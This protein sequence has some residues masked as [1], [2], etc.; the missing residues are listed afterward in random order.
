MKLADARA[1]VLAKAQAFAPSMEFP[2]PDA[3]IDFL[4]FNSAAQAMR[5]TGTVK[6]EDWMYS[7]FE[8]LVAQK[9]TFSCGMRWVIDLP[10]YPLDVY[11]A[12]GSVTLKDPY[13]SKAKAPIRL[14]K[15]ALHAFSFVGGMVDAASYVH[16]AFVQDQNELFLIGRDNFEGCGV[17]VNMIVGGMKPDS[18][19]DPDVNVPIA[20]GAGDLVL[21]RVARSLIQY[22]QATPTDNVEDYET[23]QR[24]PSAV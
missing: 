10:F 1:S 20:F 7:T 18:E 6:P 17:Y 19:C 4:V 9:K 13:A 11:D 14:R 8:C 16:P 24:S 2:A 23:G 22:I 5:E 3:L 15:V 21:D 12:I